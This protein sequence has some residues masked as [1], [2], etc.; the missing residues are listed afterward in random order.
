MTE[1][2]LLAA[3]SDVEEGYIEH[4]ASALEGQRAIPKRKNWLNLIALA[5]IFCLILSGTIGYRATH[6][7]SS[8]NTNL[9]LPHFSGPLGV[10][11]GVYHSNTNASLATPG[12]VYRYAIVVSA[13]VI[14]VLPDVYQEPGQPENYHI[15]RLQIN[16]VI[17][18]K[19][20][21]KEVYYLLSADLSPDLTEYTDIVFS[22]EQLSCENGIMLNTSKGTAETFDFLFGS[23]ALPFYSQAE[24]YIV[25]FRYGILDIGLWE[26]EGWNEVGL[27][28]LPTSPIK[29]GSFLYFPAYRGCT[30]DETKRIIR[31]RA[32]GSSANSSDSQRTVIRLSDFTS[33]A[34]QTVF[35][36]VKPFENG[37]FYQEQQNG[38]WLSYTRLINGF[39]TD[40]VITLNSDTGA[41][42]YSDASYTDKH[43]ENAPNIS[44]LIQ[45]LQ[46]KEPTP[47]YLFITKDMT[48]NY[49]RIS[50]QYVLVND[51]VYGIVTV[52]WQYRDKQFDYHNDELYY[53]ISPD[54]S[55]RVI[56]K[57]ALQI[58][59]GDRF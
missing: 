52:K 26:K 30:L 57:F 39:L 3:F 35:D 24:G 43:L 1:K 50:G 10:I 8:T 44:E 4:A 58:F 21:P 27:E 18:G 55:Y 47:P 22:L 28:H 15:L 19:N 14:E 25:P 54:G 49:Y 23:Y 31:Q 40:E 38:P 12:N 13:R 59:T 33:D 42:T 34:A 46:E 51:K 2:N 53:L 9:K 37:V 11:S 45:K 41:V 29:N 36:Y 56:S 48:R 16:D 5:A 17:V 20:L 6:R 7:L 32:Y